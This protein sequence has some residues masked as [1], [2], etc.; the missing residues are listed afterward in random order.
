L[1]TTPRKTEFVV[2]KLNRAGK[3]QKM[4]LLEIDYQE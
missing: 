4:D 2:T 1:S 3:K